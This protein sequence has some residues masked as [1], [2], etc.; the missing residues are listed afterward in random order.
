MS[1]PNQ[2]SSGRPMEMRDPIKVFY[3]DAIDN[4]RFAK[5]Q[6][7]R[8]TNY[9][10]IVLAVIFGIDREIIEPGNQWER[11]VLMVLTIVAGG[12]G[13]YYL[14]SFREFAEKMRTRLKAIYEDYF[15]CAERRRLNIDPARS[16]RGDHP[17]IGRTLMGVIAIAVAVVMD[18]L[19]QRLCESPSG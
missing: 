12:L 14:H 17:V 1:E 6:E 15:S 11:G 13:I 2:D 3:Q 18:F 5:Q 8:V 7:W 9:A 10:L 4:I 19:F 16:L